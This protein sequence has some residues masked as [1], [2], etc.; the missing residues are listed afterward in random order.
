MDFIQIHRRSLLAAG[1]V[2]IASLI[3]GRAGVRA[4]GRL[5]LSGG[6]TPAPP[7]PRSIRPTVQIR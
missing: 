1:L 2:A 7:H 3:G 5:Y 6:F 4:G